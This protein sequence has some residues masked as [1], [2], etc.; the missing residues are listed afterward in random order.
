[1]LGK[2]SFVSL[3]V[4]PD[5]HSSYI[6]TTPKKTILFVNLLSKH[7]FMLEKVGVL[8]CSNQCSETL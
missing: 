2:G 1:M 8:L 5:G 4:L 7:W 6:I 3:N